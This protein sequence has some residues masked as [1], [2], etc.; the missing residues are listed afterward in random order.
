MGPPIIQS[1]GGVSLHEQSH[2]ESFLALV[3]ERFRG[4]GLYLLDEPEAALSPM[5]QMR[6]LCQMDKLVKQGS[7]FIISTHSPILMTCPCAQ[8]M[9]IDQTGI[10][11]ISYREAEA[12]QLTRRF[13]NDPEHMLHLLLEEG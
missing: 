6:L 5:R 1:Y 11:E 8:V 13:L 9:Q 7:Q 12:F 2:G 10:R 4:Q 3:E